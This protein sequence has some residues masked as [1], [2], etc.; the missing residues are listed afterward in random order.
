MPA[1]SRLLPRHTL[2][3]RHMRK[4]ANV[5]LILFFA[6]GFLSV[7]DEISSLFGP[8]EPLS[9]FRMQVASTVLF[10]AVLLYLCMW[11][12]RRIPKRLFIPLIVFPFA[13]PMLA[14]LIPALGES[15]LYS[16]LMS[17]IQVGVPP[18]LIAQYR[19]GK[20]PGLTLP[21]WRFEGPVF[22]LK[23][24][25]F[26]TAANV[27]AL[28][29]FLTLFTL[30]STDAWANLNTGG[31]V[32]VAPGGLYMTERVY[33]RGSQ[34]VKLSGMIHVG[35]KGYYEDVTRGPVQGR[36]I[37][38]AEGVTDRSQVLKNR[39][40]YRKVAD[41]LGLASQEKM[42]F[43]GNVID[44]K[45]LDAARRP[46]GKGPDIMLADTD[47]AT[48]RPETLLF[49]NQVGKELGSHGSVVDG[50]LSL[51]RW[52]E[53]NVTP[54]MYEVIREDILTR[55]NEVVLSYL[56]RALKGYDTVVIPWGALHMKGIEAGVKERGFV[57][58]EE[59]KRLG[60]D[61]KT[62]AEANKK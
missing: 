47:L 57:L 12:D 62:I 14:W 38:L 51:N 28:P 61:F 31:F 45:A 55:R 13:V 46:A 34:T 2:I 56:D 33:K 18:L 5:F 58:K 25:L 8:V 24:T 1:E 11:V 19:D 27:V 44:D 4:F 42:L 7:L 26:F 20:E 40:D 32:R 39:F 17:L 48:F 6:D 22:G 59:K 16:I 21:S 37:V 9:L 52:A 15:R 49:L 29:V 41:F 54:K 10:F 3:E 36:T 60:V 23:N 43:S 30:S 35:E 53:K 50:V